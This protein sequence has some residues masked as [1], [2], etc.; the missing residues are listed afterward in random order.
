MTSLAA[1]S[2]DLARLV[3]GAAPAVVGLEHG[4]GQ[5]SGL[6]ISEDG[7]VLTNAHVAGGRGRLSLRLPGGEEQGAERVG[8]DPRTDLAV[9]RAGRG[10][11]KPLALDESRSAEVGEVVVAIGN[12]LGFDR[13]VSLGV[14]SALHRSLPTPGGPIDGLIQTDAAVNPGNSGGPLLDAEGAVV[15]VTTAMLPRAH[16]MAFAVPART[17]AWVAAVLIREGRVRRPF[18]GI[19]VRG[20]DLS[21]DLAREIHQPRALRIVEVEAGAPAEVGGLR[22]GDL[23]VSANERPVLT[24]DDLGRAVVL[25]PP[26]VR[27]GVVRAG[28]TRTLAVRPGPERAAA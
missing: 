17:A 10:G 25:S 15:G 1:L 21:V 16:G 2:R 18:L 7:F 14:V 12:P 8:S 20:E 23:L 11:L 3:A 9:V 28:A 19:H 27:L 6:C 4:R 5:G 13:S 26:E 22:R 24:L